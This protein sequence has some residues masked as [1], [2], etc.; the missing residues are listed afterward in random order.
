MLR[1][2]LRATAQT[3]NWIS[4]LRV[5]P[6]AALFANLALK[7]YLNKCFLARGSAW[8]SFIHRGLSQVC[9]I[10]WKNQEP[11]LVFELLL[12]LHAQ[13]LRIGNVFRVRQAHWGDLGSA[14]I[15]GTVSGH[16]VCAQGKRN[17]CLHADEH[18]LFFFWYLKCLFGCIGAWLLRGRA[19]LRHGGSFIAARGPSLCRWVCP[20]ACGI[21]VPQPW[22]APTPPTLQGGF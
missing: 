20:A 11:L 14:G 18:F 15:P 19:V 8:P 5:V 22:V 6:L 10:L 4:L 13:C 21:F 16:Q 7:N 3:P 17:W 1:H 2:G 9:H 12:T